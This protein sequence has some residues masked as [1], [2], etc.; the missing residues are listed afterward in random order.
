[1]AIDQNFLDMEW[2]NGF[3]ATLDDRVT[4]TDEYIPMTPVP[5]GNFGRLV[6]EDTS[7]ENF[8]VI[9]YNRKDAGGVY[10]EAADGGLR[11]EDG[12]SSGVHP[13]GA[14][15]RGNITAQ[16]IREMRAATKA[17]LDGF[18]DFVGEL[19]DWRPLTTPPNNV[20]YNG[21]RSYTLTIPGVDYTPYLS[22]GMRLRTTRTIAAPTRCTALTP[23]QYWNKT[24]TINKFTFTDDF[25]ISAWVKISKLPADGG[26][27]SIISRFNGTSGF[28]MR[29][30]DQ[31][32]VGI[33]GY[34]GGAGN[35]SLVTSNQAIPLNRWVHI[36]VQL[37]MSSFGNS[38]T[39]SYVMIDGQDSAANVLRSGTNPTSLSQAGS[40]EI[41]SANG[42]DY[43]DI[44][45]AQVAVFGAKVTMDTMRG[46]M[47]QGL[48]GSEPS[49]VSAWSFDN[50]TNDLNT[51]TPNNLSAVNSATANSTDSPFGV[52]ANGTPSN[53]LDYA[54][55]MAAS[56]ATNTTLVVQVPEGCTIP[57]SGGISAVHYSTSKAPYGMT[58][59]RDRWTIKLQIIASTDNTPTNNQWYRPTPV[60][61]VLPIGAWNLG[62]RINS[63]T[64]AASSIWVLSEVTLSTLTSGPSDTRLSMRISQNGASANPFAVG[65]M[66]HA[67]VG[68]NITSATPYFPLQYCGSSSGTFQSSC[69]F[70]GFKYQGSVVYAENAYL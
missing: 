65:G 43:A 36:A 58:I 48:T 67:E 7:R 32:S 30:T 62:Y 22:P 41:G 70:Y 13:R 66:Q 60:A 8:E 44:K 57:T 55:V 23:N 63:R 4:E 42:S 28:R 35:Y 46:Y 12:T 45:I 69:G 25:V 19:P 14:R 29:I 56:F 17:V 49:L 40:I 18:D 2:Q 34:N 53:L 10:V 24:G 52:Q 39:T 9:R 61:L 15:V 31:G 26:A 37:D 6:L 54:I 64:A 27:Y 3:E 68:V 5:N 50:N 47:S 51:T 11:N 38:A 1:M 59:E 33:V 21:N 20:V 16:D